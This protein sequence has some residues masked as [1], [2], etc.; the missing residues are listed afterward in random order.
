MPLAHVTNLFLKG[1]EYETKN[2]LYAKLGANFP[3]R[4]VSVLKII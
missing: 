2:V 3:I 4:P 1:R